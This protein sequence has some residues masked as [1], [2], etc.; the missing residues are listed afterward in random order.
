MTTSSAHF[1]LSFLIILYP[2]PMVSIA[3][4]SPFSLSAWELT[5][6]DVLADVPYLLIVYGMMVSTI[7]IKFRRGTEHQIRHVLSCYSGDTACP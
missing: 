5:G 4:T 1:P 2:I 6:V 7:D 3:I